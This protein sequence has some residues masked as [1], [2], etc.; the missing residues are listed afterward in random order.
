MHNS[1]GKVASQMSTWFLRPSN[2][3][4]NETQ[5]NTYHA[6]SA[7]NARRVASDNLAD[8]AANPY[9]LPWLWNQETYNQAN[10]IYIFSKSSTVWTLSLLN[11]QKRHENNTSC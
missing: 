7:N 5:Q 8:G 9:P 6:R 1:G 4:P 11:K 10:V 3:A 2:H